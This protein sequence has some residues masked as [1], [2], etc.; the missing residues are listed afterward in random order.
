MK[1][2]SVCPNCGHVGY[3]KTRVKGSILIELILWIMFIIPGVIYSIWRLTTKAKVCPMCAASCM[4]PA[5]TP[6]GRELVA[7]YGATI[8]NEKI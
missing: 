4:I 1:V 2:T 6:K 7:K 3:P 8:T 5:S